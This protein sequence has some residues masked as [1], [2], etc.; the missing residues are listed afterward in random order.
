M[1]GWAV[2]WTIISLV[3]ILL[4]HYLY[5]FFIDT[6]TVPKVKDL[7]NK[8][9]EKYNEILNTIKALPE[10]AL[11][12]PNKEDMQSELKNFLSDLKKPEE[13]N[14]TPTYYSNETENVFSTY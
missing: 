2:Q 10:P 12:A 3:L 9:A 11:D 4:V 5:S 6:L 7:V 13:V 1:I 14:S 8:P